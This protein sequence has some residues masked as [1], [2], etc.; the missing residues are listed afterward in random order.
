MCNKHNYGE[1]NR[2]WKKKY[3]KYLVLKQASSSIVLSSES[4]I[5]HLGMIQKAEDN[6]KIIMKNLGK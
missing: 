2:V 1:C 6:F 3:C 4:R 5:L